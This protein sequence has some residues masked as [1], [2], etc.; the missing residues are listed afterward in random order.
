VRLGDDVFVVGAGPIG[1]LVAQVARRAGARRI[2][3]SELLA[4]R[5]VTAVRT[6]ADDA[7]APEDAA[8]AL[9]AATAGRGADVVIEM[10]GTDGAITTA[11]HC[12]RPGAR[13]ALG[14]IPSQERSSFPAAAARRKGLTLKMVRRSH[15]AFPKAIAL[16]TSGID[17]DALVTARYPIT[18]AAEAFAAAEQRTGDK[19][20]IAVGTSAG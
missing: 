1:V 11:V 6:G 20:V 13:V 17:L 9:A 8:D 12:A 4:H 18:R 16:A 7:W 10:A 14:G 15:D 3:V 19:T 2:F 5:R